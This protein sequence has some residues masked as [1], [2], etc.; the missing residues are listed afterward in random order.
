MILTEMKKGQLAR[1]VALTPGALTEIQVRRLLAYGITP[2]CQIEMI[3][4][5]PLGGA[6]QFKLRGS[7]L[8]IA[9]RLAQAIEIE[10]TP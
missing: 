4:R 6:L 8:C 5:A 1:V 7:R 9:N 2:G 10:V 3:R